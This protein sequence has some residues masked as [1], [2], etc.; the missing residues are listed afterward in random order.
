[1]AVPVVFAASSS[2]SPAKLPPVIAAVALASVRLS[3][4]AAVSDGDAATVCPGRQVTL[5]VTAD[6][7]GGS[8]TL[9][10]L[11]VSVTAVLRLFDPLPSLSTQVTRRVGFE[12]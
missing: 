3:G 2:P 11:T 12:P 6:S 7:V 5:A 9:V 8:F 4:S 1:M 10:M